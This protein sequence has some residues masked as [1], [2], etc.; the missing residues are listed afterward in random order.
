VPQFDMPLEEL[1]NYRPRV[2]EPPDFDDFWAATLAETR[3]YPLHPTFKPVETGLHAI[4]TYDVE[5]SG[6]GGH[7]IKAWLRLPSRRLRDGRRLP[8][9]VQFQGY[10]GGRALAHENLL[11]A[12]AGYAHLLMDTRGQGSGWSAG[13]T[14]D[15]AGSGPAYSGFMTRGIRDPHEYFYRRLFADAV[16]AVEALR[17]HDE[18]DPSQVIATGASQGGG[19]TLAVSALV[20][21]IVAAMPDVPFLCHFERA[22]TFV[23]S[24]PYGEIAR[25]L[26][27]RRGDVEQAYRTLSYFDGVTM[28][29]RAAAPAL[30][31]VALMDATCPPSTVFAAF[32]AYRGSK[33]ISVYPFNDHEGG[34]SFHQSIQLRWL[35]SHIHEA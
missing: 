13:D 20:P 7:R 10:G 3:G 21:D 9:V 25:Y 32:N 17:S 27:V 29:R 16:R 19:I 24:D 12:A 2:E 35:Q 30:F 14:D 31:S 18:V 1:E 15:P 11:W 6:F 8:G 34:E 26:K 23:D 5:F 22:T 4:D 28:A 33:E